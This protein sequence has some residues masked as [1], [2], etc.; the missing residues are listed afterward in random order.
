M[1]SFVMTQLTSS[2]VARVY[3]DANERGEKYDRYASAMDLYNNDVGRNLSDNN[4]DVSFEDMAPIIA[5][6]I[7]TGILVSEKPSD[8]CG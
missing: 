6:L 4:P 2:E 7:D 5:D 1:A 8:Q 3:G